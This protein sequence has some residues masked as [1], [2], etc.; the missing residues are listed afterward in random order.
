MLPCRL[1][2]ESESVSVGSALRKKSAFS[3]SSRPD[4]QNASTTQRQVQVQ[5]LLGTLCA[6]YALASSQAARLLRAHNCSKT[7]RV[8][9]FSATCPCPMQSLAHWKMQPSHMSHLVHGCRSLW[10]RP[11]T[12]LLCPGREEGHRTHRAR[13]HRHTSVAASDVS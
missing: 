6:P 12:A 13:H 1:G 7:A 9:L 2:F 11:E 5:A 8:F 3:S 10:A 4:P